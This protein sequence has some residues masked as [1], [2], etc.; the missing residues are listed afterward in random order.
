MNKLYATRSSLPGRI[1]ARLFLVTFGFLIGVALFMPWN[2]LWASA[3]AH[4][5]EQ[6]PTVGLRWEA[7]DRDGPFGFR[8]RKLK[9]TVA[10]T[11]GSL[12]FHQAYVNVGFSPLAHVRLDTGGVQ[13]E[14]DVFQ[15]GVLDFEG[16]LNLTSLLGGTDLKGTLRVAGNLF[17]PAGST[18]PKKGWV[19]IRSQQLLLPDDKSVEDL[20]FT[21]EISGPDMQVRDLTILKPIA[22][23]A[24]GRGII[25]PDNLFQTAF[26]LNGE[27]TIGQR[28]FP[29]DVKGTLSD[30]IW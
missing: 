11:P 30:A 19:D 6:L 7:I 22:L 5:D 14:L 9:I 2:K 3:L 18:L 1:L 24:A 27:V 15:T 29:Y 23:K 10:D 16:D 13:C 21:A 8:V 26:D 17:M 25:D 4:V 20:A 12:S 28:T